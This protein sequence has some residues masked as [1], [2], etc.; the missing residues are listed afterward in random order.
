MTARA[1]KD[2]NNDFAVKLKKSVLNHGNFLPSSAIHCLVSSDRVTS[3]L[4]NIS[5]DLLGFVCLEAPRIFLICWDVS[6]IREEI[7]DFLDSL[8]RAGFNDSSLPV[9]DIREICRKFTGKRC[10][11]E[12]ALDAFHHT[13]WELGE[14]SGFLDAQW[15]FIAHVFDKND[16]RMN[17]DSDCVLPFTEWRD[18]NK[19]GTFGNVYQVA[20]P[21]DHL[22]PRILPENSHQH[23]DTHGENISAALKELSSVPADADYDVQQAWAT[24]A[25]A[26]FATRSLKT[27]HV[28]RIIVAFSRS[29]G[30]GRK[31][32]IV[33]EWAQGGNLVDFWR[34]NGTESPTR[35]QIRQYLQQVTGLCEALEELH[36]DDKT[37]TM[38]ESRPE[39]LGGG[40]DSLRPPNFQAGQGGR[41]VRH[42]DLKPAN[43]L[44]FPRAEYDWLGVLKIAD[45][46]LAKI[47]FEST[48]VRPAKTKT[49]SATRQ[50][51]A[52]EMASD[53][54]QTRS[55]RF[56]IWSM[57]CIIFESVVWLLYGNA[58]LDEFWGNGK[59]PECSAPHSLFF[60]LGGSRSQVNNLVGKWIDHI[61][62]EDD[63]LSGGHKTLIGDLLR[64]VRDK[65]L[66]VELG[67]QPGR[68]VRCS[69]ADLRFEMSEITY[70]ANKDKYLAT[71]VRALSPFIKGVTTDPASDRITESKLWILTR[72]LIPVCSS[73]LEALGRLA[74]ESQF[75]SV[76][77]V[78]DDGDFIYN[79]IQSHETEVSSLF[80]SCSSKLCRRCSHLDITQGSF[81]LRDHLSRLKKECDFCRLIFS[82][83]ERYHHENSA[84][85]DTQVNIR[86]V[87]S[88]L[89]L[90]DGTS[91][92][93]SPILSLRRGP[94]P[95]DVRVGSPTVFKTQSPAYFTLIRG[96]I[97][98]CDEN[99]SRCKSDDSVGPARLPTRLIEIGQDTIRL[100]LVGPADREKP[101]MFQ[102]IALSHRWGDKSI[103]RHQDFMTTSDNIADRRKGMPIDAL[104]RMFR[105]AIE[106]TRKLGMRHLWI[107]SICIIQEGDLCDFE[108]EA[109]HTE[110]IFRLAYCVIAAS[111]A[112]GTSDGFLGTRP[113]REF[114]T[115]RGS[116]RGPVYVCEA[117]D[118]FQHDIVEGELNKR[119][120][121]LQERALARR[122][123]YFG[124]V[125]TYWECGEGVR[126]ET[127]TKT[128]NNKEQ[129]LGDPNFPTVATNSSKGGR[130][131]LFESLY[132]KYSTL[133]LTHA[134]DRPLA[135]AGLE[136]RL[137]RAFDTKGGYG[138]F[139]LYLER[140]LLWKRASSTGLGR[141]DFP[142]EQRFQ[143]PSWSWMAYTGPIDYVDAPFSEVDWNKDLRSPWA[144]AS[145]WTSTTGD[146]AFSHVLQAA[147]Y[148]IDL[149]KSGPGIVYDSGAPPPNS[150]VKCVVVGKEKQK[151]LVDKAEQRHFS[152]IVAPRL[153]ARKANEYV[154]I[155]VAVL[156]AS[157][158]ALDEPKVDVHIS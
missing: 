17:L 83:V 129:F 20:I 51:L 140:T 12:A 86:R 96:W 127:L 71:I 88:E 82:S 57:G 141:I 66:V 68:P 46:G 153:A 38:H 95:Q 30:T 151:D 41:H 1:R 156:S 146:S 74:K 36:R 63:R 49:M 116:S 128:K 81:H 70:H 78:L 18:P 124:G 133:Q 137:I 27:D 65:L 90:T 15:K 7:V 6:S 33:L 147:A 142:P 64:L 111:R 60:T 113:S 97:K 26:L 130:I 144:S 5:A 19:H 54:T 9:R 52:P 85:V 32:Y 118:D 117:I 39:T 114:V 89:H 2:F 135:I 106:V 69:A 25:D 122:T 35:V 145:N 126:C 72:T 152:L 76:W 158:I 134:C 101:H 112:T 103:H 131:R 154:R 40:G 110:T 61:L 79:L 99:H 98:D 80:P 21:R 102:Y 24:E 109:K 53:P 93:G 143:V 16:L 138:V 44:I 139:E 42:G 77:K 62:A 94:R 56:D 28:V 50:Y 121:V 155:G 157:W 92:A 55:R 14:F 13:A 84:A 105:D 29:Q 104:P 149:P 73:T 23:T 31:Y 119:G 75:N 108:T 10:T 132:K 22:D 91:S 120:W 115:F 34:D 125:Q 136:Q 100:H 150:P 3:L 4:P 37:Q 59:Q 107:D 45:L 47:H 48:D 58:G 87:G 148:D 67:K 11:H 123:I 8:R 43:I